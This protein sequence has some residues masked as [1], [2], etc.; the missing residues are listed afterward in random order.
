MSSSDSSGL[1]NTVR[2]SR[3]L[4]SPAP[5]GLDRVG[6]R[7]AML[8]FQEVSWLCLRL[9]LELRPNF[10]AEY[11]LGG[12]DLIK[13]VVQISALMKI[14]DSAKAPAGQAFQLRGIMHPWPL[15]TKSTPK[16]LE[17]T[18]PIVCKMQKVLK[19]LLPRYVYQDI[20]SY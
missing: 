19:L 1:S 14:A 18:P 16:K 2:L 11:L 7:K 6:E 5:L 4:L 15:L 8:C 3:L 9:P 13:I 12:Q 10:V 20:C 17:R